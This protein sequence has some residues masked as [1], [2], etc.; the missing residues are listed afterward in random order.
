MKLSIPFLS[1]KKENKK[2]MKSYLVVGLGNI[3]SKFE[4]TR[5]NI[6]FD[7]VECIAKQKKISFEKLRYGELCNFNLKGKTCYILKPNTFMNLSGKSVLFWIKKK[8]IPLNNVF[9]ITDDIHLEFG[10]I[11]IRKSG[12]SGGHNGIKD[13]I[14]KLNTEK[15]PR[16]RFG[17][18]A[19]YK[20]GEKVDYVLD[21]WNKKESNIISRAIEKSAEA[22]LYFLE[23]GVEK[24][25]NHF[26][27]NAL[28]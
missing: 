26:N 15:F 13:I 2:N 10:V 3:G 19:N 28:R 12:S 16:M 1:F 9:I 24:S 22:I 20:K 11:R 25:M 21:K 6:G 8:K 17:I 4:K 27:G 18:G 7:I 23:N 5:H 14:D